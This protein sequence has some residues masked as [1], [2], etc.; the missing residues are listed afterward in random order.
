MDAT[1]VKLYS[2]LRNTRE[3]LKKKLH[4]ANGSNMIKPIIAAELRDIEAAI[5]KM[6]CGT[7]GRC[8]VSG[9]FIPLDLLMDVPTAKT[10]EDFHKL[11]SY[12]RKPLTH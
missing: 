12:Y 10:V 5:E 6:E 11:K 3:E 1:L 7:Y 9:E 2:E 4:D 8:E